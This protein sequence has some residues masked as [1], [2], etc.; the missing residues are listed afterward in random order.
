MILNPDGFGVFWLFSSLAIAISIAG[1]FFKRDKEVLAVAFFIVSFVL[2]EFVGYKIEMH[3][4]N[5]LVKLTQPVTVKYKRIEPT[6][7]GNRYYLTTI[8]NNGCIS[9]ILVDYLSYRQTEEGKT[10]M[11]TPS[12]QIYAKV[13]Q[14]NCMRKLK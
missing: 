5:K 6:K 13:L 4:E 12:Y 14:Q 8:F 2:L 3:F 7:D 10:V 1:I 9:D 11:I